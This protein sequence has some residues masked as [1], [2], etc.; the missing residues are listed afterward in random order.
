MR[1][2]R[3]AIRFAVLAALGACGGEVDDGSDASSSCTFQAPNPPPTGSACGAMWTVPISGA[4]ACSIGSGPTTS[5][6]AKFCAPTVAG[7]TLASDTSI[8]CQ[9][10]FCGKARTSM[11]RR[12]SSGDALASHL[13]DSVW[14][15]AA[16]V[17]A[18]ATL[19]REL[20]A[21]GAPAALS[22]AARAAAKDEERHTRT[23]IAIAG[24]HGVKTRARFAKDRRRARP[25][26]DVAIENAVE[27]CVHET[28]GAALALFQSERAPDARDRAALRA[29]ARDEVRHAGLAAKID[30]WIGARLSPE[31]RAR[32]ES[33]RKGAA[34]SLARGARLPRPPALAALGMPNA[35]ESSAIASS[36]DAALWT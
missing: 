34:R 15:E 3:N 28:F 33:A 11:R 30:A 5:Q 10:P 7:C 22:R 24:R 12:R 32:V 35:R 26:V 25:L 27:G 2:T 1:N 9:M 21:H 31:E 20:D 17:D 8:D 6:C 16:S 29:I 19:A 36:L 13:R 23:T 14:L 4:A 18:F